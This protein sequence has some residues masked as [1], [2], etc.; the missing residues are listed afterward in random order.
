MIRCRGRERAPDHVGGGHELE[1]GSAV[2]SS[3][4]APPKHL[5]S[6]SSGEPAQKTW[7]RPEWLKKKRAF[8][9]IQFGGD[10]FLANTR[11]TPRSEIACTFEDHRTIDPMS[12]SSSLGFK[13]CPFRLLSQGGRAS[14]PSLSR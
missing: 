2:L 12:R 14:R 9:L 1:T 3:Q 6:F 7:L 13:L 4:S 11:K 8:L 5:P 10:L